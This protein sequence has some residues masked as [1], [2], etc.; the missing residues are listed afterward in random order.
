[1]TYKLQEDIPLMNLSGV[2]LYLRA[3]I[4]LRFVMPDLQ[5]FLS[6][7]LKDL[8][9]ISNPNLYADLVMNVNAGIPSDSESR[10][11]SYLSKILKR[12]RSHCI[13]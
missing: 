6:F 5:C 10:L 3:G 12:E 2:V 4:N 7:L 8:T 9:S 11:L 1:M 13:K